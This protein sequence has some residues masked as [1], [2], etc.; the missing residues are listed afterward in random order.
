MEPRGAGALQLAFEQLKA[1]LLAEGLFDADRKRP[2]PTFPKCIGIVTSPTGAVIRDIV[3]IVRTTTRSAEPAH[4]SSH[5]A[6]SIQLSLDRRGHTLVQRRIRRWADIIIVARGGGSLEDLAGFNDEGLARVIAAS[7]LPVVSAI[8]HETDFT[9][10]DFVADL[11]AATPSAA[12]ELVTDRATPTSKST[13]LLWLLACTG[14][15]GFTCCMHA[16]AIPGSR[17]SL[18]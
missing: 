2:L 5:H 3:T 18:F 16:N 7:E 6:G 8:G 1:R 9:I 14:R 13:S 12:A 4:I 10:V 11:R 15:E 17:R